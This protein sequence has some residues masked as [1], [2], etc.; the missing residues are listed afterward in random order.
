MH[1]RFSVL[2]SIAGGRVE[3]AARAE[4]ICIEQTI[5]FPAKFVRSDFIR[6]HVFGRIESLERIGGR[7]YAAK[8]SFDLEVSGSEFTQFLN[9]IFGNISLKPGVRVEDIELSDGLYA[10]LKGP[11]FGRE[12]LRKLTGIRK[13][14]LLCTALKPLGLSSKE[15]AGLAYNFALGGID[16]IK[17]DHGVADQCFAPFEERVE[18]CAEAIRK[19]DAETGFKTIY[20]PNVTAPTGKI[21]ERARFARK[22]GAGGLLIAPGLTGFDAV[23]ALADDDSIALPIFSHPSFQGSFVVNPESGISHYALFGLL[24][25]LA[26]ADAAIFPNFGGRFSFSEEECRGIVR[27]TGVE[28]GGIERIFPCPGGGMSLKRVPEMIAFYGADVILLIG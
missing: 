8:I 27:G 1:E 19:A 2:Y 25:R 22:C 18:L 21:I 26:G 5:E 14:A 24:N 20:I 28:K 15:L 6:G 11:R 12:G 7:R 16:M 4:D 3:A 17:D 9:V 13:R 10:I 23:R